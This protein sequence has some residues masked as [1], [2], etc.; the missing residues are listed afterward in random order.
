M[1]P[2]KVIVEPPDDTHAWRIF[3]AW[4]CDMVCTHPFTVEDAIALRALVRATVGEKASVEV[5]TQRG[6]KV[7]VRVDTREWVLDVV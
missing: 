5:F 4:L 3:T 2:A 6:D 7:Y 1:K